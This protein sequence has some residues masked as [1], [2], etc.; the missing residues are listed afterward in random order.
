MLRHSGVDPIPSPRTRLVRARVIL[1]AG[2]L[3]LLG[4]AATAGA[5]AGAT[6]SA[7]AR[8]RKVAKTPSDPF[9]TTALTR[10]LKGRA[11]SATIA[12]EDLADTSTDGQHPEWLFNPRARYQTASIIKVDIL[13]TLLHHNGGPLSGT[14]AEIAE[15][16]IEDSDNDDATDLWD[17]DDTTSGIA[18]YNRIAG[19]TQTTPSPYWG[20]TLTSAADQIKLL[21]NLALP[22]KVLST[23]SQRYQLELMRD[24]DPGQGW[25][26][27]GGVPHGVSVALKNGWVPISS[28]SDW[29]INS[30]GWVRGDGR[31]YLIAVLTD[32]NP[33]EGYG[34]DTIQTVSALIYKD[35]APRT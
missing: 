3:A 18:A 24:I 6:K 21:A 27:T 33:G 23:A 29:E 13:E 32:D 12:V 34:I 11:D 2:T 4:L 22:S 17:L 10:Y 30:I 25:G 19:L 15:G 28:D 16:M 9:A 7:T 1:A 31:N 8:S 5:T 14:T 26:V 35:L 20:E